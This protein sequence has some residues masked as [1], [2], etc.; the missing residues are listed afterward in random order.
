MSIYIGGL[1][2]EGVHNMFESENVS[3]RKTAAKEGRSL[4]EPAMTKV[5]RNTIWERRIK[6]RI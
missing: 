3:S 1:N 4:E 6:F 5:I 2:L